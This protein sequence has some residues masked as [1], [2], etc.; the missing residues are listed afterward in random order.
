LA[1]FSNVRNKRI[2]DIGSAVILLVSF[3]VLFLFVKRPAKYLLNC[4]RV[5]FGR[6]TWVGYSGQPPAHLPRI[7]KGI[8]KPYNI[9]DGYLPPEAA[10]KQIDMAYAQHYTTLSDINLIFKNLPYLGNS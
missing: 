6:A 5:L 8:L 7:K 1:D 10:V 4:F 2:L 3:P 9:V